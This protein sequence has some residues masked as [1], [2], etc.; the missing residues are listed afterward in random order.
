MRK[1]DREQALF[2]RDDRPDAI[3]K[4]SPM[5]AQYLAIK[6]AHP[7]AL[8]FYRMGDFYELFFGDAEVA[9][10][11]L[12]IVLTQRGKHEGVAIPMCGVP[13]ERSDDYLHRLIKQGHRVA[14][15]EQIEDPAEARK[16]GGKSVV[17]RAVV[18]LVTPGTL[19]ED[20]L[21][22]PE[23]ANWLVAVSRVKSAEGPWLF[24]LAAVDISTGAFEVCDTPLIGLASE[25]GRIDP[26]EI[27][28]PETIAALP[29]VAGL[30]RDRGSPV[31]KLGR[32][33][34][35][36]ERRLLD[37]YGLATLEGLGVLS[38]AEIAAAATAILYLERTQCGARPTLHPPCRARRSSHMEVDAA[39]RANLE[40]MRTLGG[41]REGSLLGAIDR[42]VTPAGSRMLAAHLSN[43]LTERAAI[44]ARLDAVS[45][46]FDNRAFRA[47]A[48]ALLKSAPDL[49]R[50]LSRIGLDR[51]GP[52]DLAAIRDGLDVAG[53]IATLLHRRPRF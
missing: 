34:G 36:A 22:E 4:P 32:E 20:R 21:L 48:R 11:A 12:G 10:K 33:P 49:A 2:I 51:A 8:L 5:I 47:E 27:V 24:G 50:A 31:T 35:S 29:E 53:K 18:R 30:L 43:P 42:C 23:R 46:F 40:L 13:V 45:F 6:A 3:T 37:F 41:A 28:L 25:F 14:I 38:G 26:R 9:A 7:D 52:R 17:E 1:T 16:R 39:T 44:E 19:T 15:C